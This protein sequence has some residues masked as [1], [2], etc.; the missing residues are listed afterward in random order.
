MVDYFTKQYIII[1]FLHVPK[2]QTMNNEGN[3]EKFVVS[4]L[5]IPHGYLFDI[6]LRAMYIPQVISFLKAAYYD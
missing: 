4:Y 2:P 6:K 1:I 5:T 3:T